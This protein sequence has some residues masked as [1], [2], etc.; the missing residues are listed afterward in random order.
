MVVEFSNS[1][2]DGRMRVTTGDGTNLMFTV[3][4]QDIEVLAN[5]IKAHCGFLGDG[6]PFSINTQT[7][8]IK[9]L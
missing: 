6:E 5:A 2:P 9:I 3:M 7:G 4:P 1:E 8:E